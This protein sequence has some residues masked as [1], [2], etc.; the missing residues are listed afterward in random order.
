[1]CCQFKKLVLQDRN[2][3]DNA[4]F[5]QDCFEVGRRFK[6]MNPD[7][8]RAEYGKLIYML[9]DSADDHIQSLLEFRSVR[10]LRTVHSLLAECSGL[11]VLDDPLVDLATAE[12][13]AGQGLDDSS[14]HRRSIYSQTH[15]WTSAHRISP[16]CCTHQHYEAWHQLLRAGMA[17]KIVCCA[18]SRLHNAA[19]PSLQSNQAVFLQRHKSSYVSC[20]IVR[21]CGL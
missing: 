12:I 17:L 10:P 3:Q 1:M 14:W 18:Q 20:G 19:C 4:E 6:I 7:K 5:F 16:C 21:A 11:S 8:M 13:V 9:M 2:F 15:Y